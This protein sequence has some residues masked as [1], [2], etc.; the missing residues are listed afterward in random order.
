MAPAGNIHL[1]LVHGSLDSVVHHNHGSGDVQRYALP[2]HGSRT[3]NDCLSSPIQRPMEEILV[4][5]HYTTEPNR[6]V[7]VEGNI[8]E[9]PRSE[10]FGCL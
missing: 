2:S 8:L 7:A 10:T 9:N 1:G 4:G 5:V 6:T 3:A